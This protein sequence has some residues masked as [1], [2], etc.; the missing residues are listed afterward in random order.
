MPCVDRDQATVLASHSA[1]SSMTR[2]Y[3]PNARPEQFDDDKFAVL[4][5]IRVDVGDGEFW[6]V[7]RSTV[8]RGRRLPIRRTRRRFDAT[9]RR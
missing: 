1:D 7:L 2:A 5:A 6:A 9:P 4:S 8:R 3:C